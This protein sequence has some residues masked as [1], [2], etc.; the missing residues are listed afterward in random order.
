MMDKPRSVVAIVWH[1]WTLVKTA[2]PVPINSA[3]EMIYFFIDLLSN[4]FKYCAKGKH[5]SCINK[6]LNFW[7]QF[8]EYFVKNTGFLIG[9]FIVN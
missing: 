9:Y 2:T 4:F 8:G 3:A 7:Y 5:Y 1:D 6:I